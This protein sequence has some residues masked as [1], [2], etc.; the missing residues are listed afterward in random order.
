MSGSHRTILTLGLNRL[1][2]DVILRRLPSDPGGG[3]QHRH[4]SSL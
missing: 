2:G 4:V 3:C 1:V